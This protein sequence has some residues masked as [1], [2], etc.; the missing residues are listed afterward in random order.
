MSHARTVAYS[1]R[2]EVSVRAYDRV[3]LESSD[4]PEVHRITTAAA[5]LSDDQRSRTR[6]YL[7]SMSIRTLCFLGAVFA[8]SPWRWILLVGA[9][10]LPY[11]AV[12]MANAGQSP[13]RGEPLEV[14]VR[15]DRPALNSPE[16]HAAP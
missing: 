9:V 10:F 2:G 7:I 11:V 8:P 15:P 5:G 12:V 14:V 3:V 1:S 13:P 4:H 6:R 16:G